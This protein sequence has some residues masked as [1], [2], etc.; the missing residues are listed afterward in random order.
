MP[1]P[2]I[3]SAVGS[4][5]ANTASRV[6]ATIAG[7]WF[8]RKFPEKKSSSQIVHV[9]PT[10]PPVYIE[11]AR[12]DDRLTRIQ[13]ENQRQLS[14]LKS[15]ELA[16][17]REKKAIAETR[18]NMEKA[19][20]SAQCQNQ[21]ED[22]ALR[23]EQNEIAESRLNL[24]REIAIADQLYK[25]EDLALRR[26]HNAIAQQAVVQQAKLVEIKQ[27]EVQ[28]VER[29]QHKQEELA[30]LER[31]FRAAETALYHE[32]LREFKSKDIQLKLTEIQANWDIK[33]WPSSLSRDETQQLLQ[34]GLN[35]QRLLMLISPP[36]I[37][38]S[39][40]ESFHNDLPQEIRNRV[41]HFLGKHFPLNGLYPVEF[42]GNYF[43]RDIFDVEI[44]QL[45]KIL[46]P[47]PT[48]VIYSDITEREVY[49]HLGVWGWQEDTS[50]LIPSE[51]WNWRQEKKMLEAEG[52]DEVDILYL[53]RQQI[54]DFYK[55]YAALIADW[56]YLNLDRNYQPQLLNLMS[57]FPEEWVASY[58]EL[59]EEVHGAN[60]ATVYYE[61][62]LRQAELGYH[63]LAVASYKRA[64]ELQSD[65][66][67]AMIK[68]GIAL[69]LSGQYEEAVT[70]LQKA[71]E[72]QSQ[73]DEAWYYLG[74][75]RGSLSNYKGALSCFEMLIELK[76]ND[77]EYWFQWGN[78][79]GIL[80]R[81]VAAI[82]ALDKAISLQPDRV[83][84]W[85]D[86]A[87]AFCQLRW[88]LEAIKAY[89]KVMEIQ[90]EFPQIVEKRDAAIQKLVKSETIECPEDNVA[91]AWSYRG[92]ILYRL[93]L[94]EE[95]ISCYDKAFAIAA[96]NPEGWYNRAV[97][98]TE[99][100]WL[101][102]A[103]TS[104]EQAV[105]LKPD[106]YEAWYGKGEVLSQL[107]RYS[108]AMQAYKQATEV[109]PDSK[110]AAQKLT[111]M[112][113]QYWSG[114]KEECTITED[115]HAANFVVFS[116]DGKFLASQ[117]SDQAIK[118]WSVAT[119]KLQRTLSENSGWVYSVAF[120]SDREF[121]VSSSGNK[122]IQMWLV[123]TWELQRTLTGHSNIILSVA[124]SPDSQFI[125]S[126][127]DDS[128]I[129]IWLVATGQEVRTLSG[130]S[131]YVRSVAISPDSQ[132]IASG[133]A[134]NTIKIWS[135][136]TGEI[137]RTITGHSHHVYSVA[138]SPEGKHLASGSY[139][140]TI[141]I[142][143]VE[144]GEELYTFTG[145]SGA[146]HSLAFSPDGQF[147]AYAGQDSTIKILSVG[148]WE[149][150]CSL[151]GHYNRVMSVAFSPDGKLIASSSEDKTIKI[152]RAP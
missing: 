149:E 21:Q 1:L 56:Y 109:E 138:F 37:S 121:I 28:L 97:A 143:S 128:T 14:V 120:N 144:T 35:N 24:E 114:W 93:G 95:A 125:A 86:K 77:S 145:H 30:R 123:E 135:A 20:A 78:V 131:S 13:L 38:K 80:G 94:L 18:L 10:P 57:D 130:H 98:M 103:A 12:N 15:E 34:V 42:Y 96:D 126:G 88:Y 5:V 85:Y 82:N 102:Q 106:Y 40:P 150:L 9:S 90:A 140:K 151:K 73:A 4:F 84:A 92:G 64:Q 129:K 47:I 91:E 39:C 33:N 124:I 50:H 70:C 115:S 17:R 147:L 139:D 108:E 152:W 101:E 61:E 127:S 7:K 75:A 111:Q 118:M 99:L 55:L 52:E 105:G 29:W 23:R 54:V 117:G 69:Y 45:E 132:F 16:L 44:R 116:P 142:W 141:K 49:F 22:L 25:R 67:D 122:T 66:P 48:V 63:D 148:K 43:N 107:Q 65:F 112:Y 87:E 71:T 6:T 119:G 68:E 26:E 31:E 27:Q 3:F 89:S 62:G 110:I 81:P 2:A 51:P 59:M 83:D 113:K 137:Q 36:N 134:D 100:G 72:L 104:Y 8:E 19:I 60:L 46:S 74:L 79:L 58:V 136:K 53:I 76:P 11:R 146:Y 133:S 32:L 41:K